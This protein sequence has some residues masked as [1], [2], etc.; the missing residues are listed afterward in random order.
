MLRNEKESRL[1][2]NVTNYGLSALQSVVLLSIIVL[3]CPEIFSG[4]YTSFSSQKAKEVRGH[5]IN[6]VGPEFAN[7]NKI[8]PRRETQL[9][10]TNRLRHFLREKIKFFAGIAE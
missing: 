8:L 3:F 10:K 5:T 1:L 9:N 2:K 6:S 4:Y 7:S